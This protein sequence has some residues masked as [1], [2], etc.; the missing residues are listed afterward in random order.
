MTI[1]N[2]RGNDV[3]KWEPLCSADGSVNGSFTAAALQ[4]VTIELLYD[5]AMSFLM[6]CPQRTE[7][8]GT[9]VESDGARHSHPLLASVVHGYAQL[10]THTHATKKRKF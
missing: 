5:P 2:R 1:I 6:L 10:Y 3:E 4:K 8:R 9:R 7:S